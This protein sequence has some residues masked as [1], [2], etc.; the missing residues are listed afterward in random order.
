MVQLEQNILNDVV[1]TL[2]EMTTIS[3]PYYLFEFISDDTNEAK[4]FTGVDISPNVN[5]YNEFTIE[6]TS[7]AEDLLNS[8]ITLPIKGFYTYSIYSQVDQTNLDIANITELVEMGK[9]YVNDTVKP[10]KK[11]YAGGNK[12]KV[13]YN[14]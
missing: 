1:V 11:S 4:I 8:V 10:V 13:V 5:R 14:G 9:V 6:L 2:R 7:G 3:N 12:T